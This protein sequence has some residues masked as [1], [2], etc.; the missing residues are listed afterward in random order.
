MGS[1]RRRIERVSGRD[2]TV[3]D[4][5]SLKN[6]NRLKVGSRDHVFT[7]LILP[8]SPAT[9]DHVSALERLGS[10]NRNYPRVLDKEHR[11]GQIRVLTSW[12]DGH[13]LHW[14]LDRGRER[15]QEWPSLDR[16][17][18]LIKGLSHALFFAHGANLVHTDLKPANLVLA[19]KPDR[20]VLIDFG[21]ALTAER[22][23][24]RS[25]GDGA[26]AEYAAPEVW[27]TE[28]NITPDFRADIFSV[29]VIAFEMLTGKLPFEGLGGKIARPEFAEG[30]KPRP[31]PPSRFLKHPTRLP[32]AALR[33]LDETLARGLALNRE[34]RFASSGEFRT[35]WS[36]VSDGLRDSVRDGERP[37]WFSRVL[38]LFR[39]PS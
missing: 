14:Y 12:I 39:R 26:T 5:L 4:T 29:S 10:D 9:R 30:E 27:A 25:D 31:E 7:L 34:E 13:T 15:P 3:L 37:G 6:G 22:A 19:R 17:T 18:A 32:R 1:Q 38:G 36:R 33:V 24:R 11:G 8:D 23:T 35:A 16:T 28:P 2:Y 20:L 21:S